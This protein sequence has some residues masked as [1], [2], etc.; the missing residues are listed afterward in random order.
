MFLHIL[1]KAIKMEGAHQQH[2]QCFA[3]DFH[4]ESKVAVWTHDGIE[5]AN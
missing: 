3:K 1:L 4:I 2:N 5:K